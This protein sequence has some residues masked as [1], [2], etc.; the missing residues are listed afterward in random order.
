MATYVLVHGGWHGGWCWKKVTPLL[1][2][3]GHE[4]Y[5]PTLTGMGERVHLAGPAVS[6]ETNIRDIEQLLFYEDLHDVI[7]VGH[8][9]AGMVISGVAE[10]VAERLAHLVYF[11]AFV[12]YDGESTSELVVGSSS[13]DPTPAPPPPGTLARFGVTAEAD[14]RWAEPRLTSVPGLTARGEG[15]RVR[16]GSPPARTTLPR[17]YIRCTASP[18]TALQT[19]ARRAQEEGGWRYV[20]LAANHDAMITHPRETADLLLEVA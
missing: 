9:Y 19:A 11:D 15:G 7:L 4:V 12:P 18:V 20:E 13:D 3:A 2:A 16:L 17:T 5:T 10:R 1:R 8:S 14:L 6:L